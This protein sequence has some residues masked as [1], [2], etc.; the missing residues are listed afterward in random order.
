MAAA[1]VEHTRFVEVQQRR[2]RVLA[3]LTRLP[4][5]PIQHGRPPRRQRERKASADPVVCPGCDGTRAEPMPL[6]THRDQSGLAW[7]ECC[8][9][10]GIW[11][12][13][14]SVKAGALN[15]HP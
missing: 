1:I 6:R 13:P 5:D 11:S 15:E 10:R 14:T 4:A 7:Y 8:E 9:C 2:A 12:V 3:E